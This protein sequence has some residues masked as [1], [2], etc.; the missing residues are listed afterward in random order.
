MEVERRLVAGQ[1]QIG[2]VV[3]LDRTQV[4]PVAVKEVGQ[5]PVRA[6]APREDFPAEIRGQRRG[7]EQIQ[8]RL[9]RKQ[10]DAHARQ[11]FPAARADAA[12]LEPCR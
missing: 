9:F 4:F 5:N 1:G 6:D 7:Y 3:R 8:Q 2:F 10:I 12:T 11:E